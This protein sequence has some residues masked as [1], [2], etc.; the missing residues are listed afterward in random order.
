MLQKINDNAYRIRLPSNLKTS[1]IF[2][3]KHLSPC[4]P[5][6]AEECPGSRANLFQPG[7]TD[8]G[9]SKPI[10]EDALIQ[11]AEKTAVT[12]STKTDL[13]NA[14]KIQNQRAQYR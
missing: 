3:V 11:P 4:F 7:E 1:D 12:E 10:E 13:Q 6:P 8:A 2:N 5:D 14:R 9:E